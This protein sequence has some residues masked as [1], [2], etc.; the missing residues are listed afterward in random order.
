[1]DLNKLLACASSARAAEKLV[2]PAIA[3]TT[4]MNAHV[5]TLF[6]NF[7]PAHPMTFSTS[8]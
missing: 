5:F 1:M 2:V 8:A 7:Q 4:T 3:T 6:A